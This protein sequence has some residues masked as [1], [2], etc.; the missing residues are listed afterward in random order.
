MRIE[1]DKVVTIDFTMHDD[2]TNE[3][4]ETSENDTPLIYLHGAGE[5]PEGLEDELDG[6]Q[7]GDTVTVTLEPDLAY[8]EREEDLVTS[9]PREQFEGIDDLEI[10]MRF[11]AETEEGPQSVRI[12]GFDGD[13]VIVDGNEQYAGR[14]VRFSVT[15]LGV[16]DATEEELEHG[17]VHGDHGCGDHDHE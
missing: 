8:G 5:L 14:T 16:R 6:K 17:H 15:I 4:L 9:V 1:L 13:D 10:G 3:L 12:I 7:A 2:N 11:E